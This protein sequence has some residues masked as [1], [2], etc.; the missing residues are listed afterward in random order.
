MEQKTKANSV[1]EIVDLISKEFQFLKND[2]EV[3][4]LWFRAENSNVKTPLIPNSYR[5][6][7]Q[8]GDNKS[9]LIDAKNIENDITASFIRQS[10]MYLNEKR[11]VQNSW[12]IYFL[13][14]HYGLS[15]R[16]LDWTESALIAL[17]FGLK[18]EENNEDI[19]LWILAPHRLNE[20]TSKILFQPIARSFSTIYFPE[21]SNR[22]ELFDATKR[23]NLDELHRKYLKMDFADESD[24]ITE[25]FYPLAIYPYLFDE[26]M[27]TQQSCFTIF[28]N[29]MNGILESPQ[30]ESFLSHILING[31]N[32][33]TILE[34]LRWL[35]VSEQNIYPGLDGICKGINQLFK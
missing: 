21:F 18:N 31:K 13:M 12:N 19:K 1:S 10:I 14:Q 24:D 8:L 29:K 9:N 17:Y 7:Y 2:D 32:K 5:K 26:R 3:F 16:L 23:I 22:R 28:G 20:N 34:E 30:K 15:T 33:K 4:N 6:I 35:G 27:K 11:I 25:D